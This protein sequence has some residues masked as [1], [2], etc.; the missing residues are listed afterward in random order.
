MAAVRRSL[1]IRLVGAPG[2][3]T[4]PPT[5]TPSARILDTTSSPSSSPPTPP[6]Q[7]PAHA[8]PPAA[9]PPAPGPGPPRPAQLVVPAPPAPGRRAAEP[10]RPDG[11]VRLRP[12]DP[13]GERAGVAQP[14]HLGGGQQGHGLPHGQHAPG[15]H[16]PAPV[17]A[18]ARRARSASPPRSPPGAPASP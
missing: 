12:G 9:A 13:K 11:H 17:A 3:R 16:D 18:M 6:P 5:S 14:P 7:P 1:N 4:T 10:P 8:S 15:G 2:S